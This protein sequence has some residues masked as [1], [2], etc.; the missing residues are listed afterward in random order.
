[1]AHYEHLPIFKQLFD[2][3]VQVE[4]AVRHF[5]RY[6]KYTLGSEMR[7]LCH[8]ALGL[9]AEANS[10]RD[11]LTLLLRLRFVLERLKIHFMLAKEVQAFQRARTF[12]R[13]TEMAVDASRQNEGWLRSV[14]AGARKNTAARS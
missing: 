5:P 9:V 1:M 14:T 7:G 3:S 8:E 10:T 12:Y 2:L 4:K 6:Y 13:I 11:R